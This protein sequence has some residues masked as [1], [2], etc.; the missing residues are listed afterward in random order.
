MHYGAYQGCQG[1]A[2]SHT[3]WGAG[4]SPTL[5]EGTHEGAR[6]KNRVPLSVPPSELF[7]RLLVDSVVQQGQSSGGSIHTICLCA[8]WKCFT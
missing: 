7:L 8:S 3:E 5:S 1:R 2:P 4:V 6:R